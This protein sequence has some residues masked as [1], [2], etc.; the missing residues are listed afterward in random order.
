MS[1][2]E[3]PKIEFPCANYP[4][5][6]MGLANLE[7]Q[8]AVLDIIQKHDPDFDRTMFKIQA[9]SKGRFQSIT[10]FIEATGVNQ[11]QAIFEDL[12]KNP[13]TRMVL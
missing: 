12:K 10:V 11:L 9:S 4:I 3:P 6:I 1:Q 5:K 8:E 2:S 7:Y 13:A